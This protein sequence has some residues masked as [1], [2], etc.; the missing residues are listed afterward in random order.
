MMVGL[1]DWHPAIGLA[2]LAVLAVLIVWFI[3][4]RRS[5]QD[6]VRRWGLDPASCRVLASD[7]ARHRSRPSL[8]ADGLAGSPDAL[9]RERTEGT[10]IV[11]EAKSRHYRGALTAYERYQVTLYCGMARRVYRRPVR[12]IILYGNGRRVPLTFDEDLYRDLLAIRGDCLRA[13][14]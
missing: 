10:I 7:L 14:D 1:T 8:V 5:P 3:V 6:I 11:G 12:A 13:M 9:M 4:R 2:L